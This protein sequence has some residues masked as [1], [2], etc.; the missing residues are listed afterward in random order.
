MQSKQCAL[1]VLDALKPTLRRVL[2]SQLE[3]VVVRD[4]PSINIAP[5]EILTRQ[6]SARLN[7]MARKNN[8]GKKNSFSGRYMQLPYAVL[9]SINY[10][11]LPPSAKQLLIDIFRQHNG[12]NNG[13]LSAS[14]KIMHKRGWK[15][16]S[17]LSR[18]LEAL[19][20]S[21]L[22]IKTR[23]GWFQ[24]EHS[25]RC[26]LYAVTWLGI[27]ECPGKDLDV[28][29]NPR[30]SFA[31]SIEN[32]KSSCPEMRA[33]RVHNRGRESERDAA[34]RYVSSPKQGR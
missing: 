13:D 26:A 7:L 33:D 3:R 24:G 29:A 2:G 17:T 27:A 19:L 21:D 23:E 22:I 32:K 1:T 28:K 18:A 5:I 12:H 14:F 8:H 9:D 25:S 16:K 11:K 34:G 10:R 15:S 4:A 31:F 6:K 20:K 30:P